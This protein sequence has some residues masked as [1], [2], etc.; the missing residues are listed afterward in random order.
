MNASEIKTV[1]VAS[2]KVPDLN[3]PSEWVLQV[4][5]HAIP[6]EGAWQALSNPIEGFRYQPGNRY[7]LKVAATPRQKDTVYKLVEVVEME[8]DMTLRLHDVW[9]LQSIG[10]EA[11]QTPR[12]G[13]EPYMEINLTAGRIQG[14]APCNQFFGKVAAFGQNS[15]R[16]EHIGSTKMA[17]PQ[18]RQE[19]LLLEALHWSRTYT[20]ENNRLTLFN[21]QGKVVVVFR[22]VD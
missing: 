21:A 13:E 16:F 12:G 4:Q 8:P 6:V 22:K 19:N 15:V 5:W 11:Y 7:Q 9:A 20:I 1:W 18:L 2:S 17:C 10:T 3:N 14:K